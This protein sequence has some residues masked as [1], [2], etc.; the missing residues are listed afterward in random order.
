M[1]KGTE[2]HASWSFRYKIPEGSTTIFVL[3][4]SPVQV[5]I[6]IGK[7]GTVTAALAHTVGRLTNVML[8]HKS[9][10]D[11]IDLL[12]GIRSDS[13]VWNKNGSWCTGLSEALS[14]ALLEFSHKQ[15][16]REKLR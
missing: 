14:F 15:K 11:V 4:T 12:S 13:G 16:A 9:L 3:E 10:D 1:T 2:G 5:Q 7:A 8:A 6:F